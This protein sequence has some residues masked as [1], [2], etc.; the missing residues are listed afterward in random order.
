M[1]M[2]GGRGSARQD[3][4]IERRQGRIH[5]IDLAFETLDLRRRNAQRTSAKACIITRDCMSLL[6]RRGSPPRSIEATPNPST[7]KVPSIA[8]TSK[9]VKNTVIAKIWTPCP[10]P[11]RARGSHQE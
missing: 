1:Q 9:I 2:S 4:R 7:V 3:E 10:L 8:S 6:E 5:G 11:A